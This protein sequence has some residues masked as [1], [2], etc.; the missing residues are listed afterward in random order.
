[1]ASPASVTR[2]AEVEGFDYANGS[3]VRLIIY[4]PAKTSSALK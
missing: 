3:M 2:A 4:S 1:L